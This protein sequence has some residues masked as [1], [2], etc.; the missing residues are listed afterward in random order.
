MKVCN[1]S[2]YH[3][4]AVIYR[5]LHLYERM[6]TMEGEALVFI[7]RDFDAWKRRREQRRQSEKKIKKEYLLS[8]ILAF[9]LCLVSFLMLHFCS[10]MLTGKETNILGST[11]VFCG[12]VLLTV[13]CFL[14]WLWKKKRKKD[15]TILAQEMRQMAS[16]WIMT[17]ACSL[18]T[19]GV[20]QMILLSIEEMDGWF[21]EEL[22]TLLENIRQDPASYK[23][24]DSFCEEFDDME[25]RIAM[26]V[27]GRANVDGCEQAKQEIF[28]LMEQLYSKYDEEEES[29]SKKHA[30]CLRAFRR[31]PLFIA[32]VK[33]MWDSVLV[34]SL[35][36]Q[37]MTIWNGG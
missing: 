11:A 23:P 33:I 15:S 6:E 1:E 16:Y 19:K 12:M 14:L 30:L 4:I 31:I 32:G 22:E 37:Q 24:Y 28:F 2:L 3:E 25:F 36:V 17:A 7:T 13:T 21:R 5:F 8:A 9:I 34:F 18:Q 35:L 29:S 10:F 27:L 20:Y 26:R